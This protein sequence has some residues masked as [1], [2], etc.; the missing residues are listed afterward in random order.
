MLSHKQIWGAID[1]LAARYGHSASGLARAAG[2][3]PTTFNKSKRLGPQGRLRWPSTE[4]LAKILQVTGASLDDFV[5]FVTRGAGK[6]GGPSRQL[7]LLKLKDA[8][9]KQVFDAQ[10][11]P[12]GKAWD[13]IAFPDLDDERAFALEISS[14]GAAPVF[15]VGDVVVVSPAAE[16]RRDDRVVIRTK[17]GC[18]V[19]RFVRQTTKRVELKSLNP[20][21]PDRVLDKDG[22]EWIARIVFVRI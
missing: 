22:V 16:L 19:M 15:R 14:D 2:L 4:S 20:S 11:R 5:G 10:G 17:D 9:K 12:M 1:T 13:Q 6:R 21:L 8:A 3:D 18:S 7:P